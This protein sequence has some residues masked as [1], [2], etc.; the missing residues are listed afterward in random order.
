MRRLCLLVVVCVAPLLLTTGTYAQKAGAPKKSGD[1][2][3]VAIGQENG[4]K[5][6]PE[7]FEKVMREQ[8][9]GIYH[10]IHS[11]VLIGSKATRQELLAGVDWMCQNA[12]ANDLVMVFIAC[13]GMCTPAGES[14]FFTKTGKVRPQ[15]IKQAL[16]GLPCQAIVI[17]DACCSGNWP[18]EYPGDRMPPNVT[19]LCCCQSNQVSGNE[20]DVTLFEALYGKADFNKDGIV[21]L[22]EVIKYC[23]LRIKEVQGGKLT[24]VLHKAKNLKAALPLTTTCPD[25]VSVIDQGAVYSGLVQKQVGDT[26][27]IHVIGFGEKPGPFSITNSFSRANV[28]LPKDGTPVM[29][30]TGGGWQPACLLS[31]DAKGYTVHFVG[32]QKGEA[33]VAGDQVR[34]L[35]AGRPGELFPLK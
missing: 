11:R 25:L 9:R 18:V 33:V 7:G 3:M 26:Y 29:V 13:H 31:R 35:F 30:K 22:D 1:L 17:N 6:L 14:V 24:P 19:A 28:I 5:C 23:G 12:K 27:H 34:H 16:A 21:E 8:G 10:D 4:W 2:Y 15:E 20:F 32:A